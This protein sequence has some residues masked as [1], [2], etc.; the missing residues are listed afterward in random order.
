MADIILASDSFSLKKL[1]SAAEQLEDAQNLMQKVY[2]AVFST[3]FWAEANPFALLDGSKNMNVF[4]GTIDEL[5]TYQQRVHQKEETLRTLAQRIEAAVREL[6]ETDQSFRGKLSGESRKTTWERFKSTVRILVQPVSTTAILLIGAINGLF[7][8]DAAIGGETRISGFAEAQIA[9]A[10][11]QFD[12]TDIEPTDEEINEIAA[13]SKNE[14][15]LLKQFQTLHADKMRME[16]EAIYAEF[17]WRG[18]SVT[19][20]EKT[21]VI[22]KASGKN[23]LRMLF[24]KLYNEKLD[25]MSD[26]EKYRRQVDIINAE[27]IGEVQHYQRYGVTS[28]KYID[29]ESVGQCTW[30]AGTTLI[31]RKRIAEG[32]DSGITCEDLLNHGGGFLQNQPYKYNGDQYSFNSEEGPFTEDRLRQLLDK[33]PEGIEIYWDPQGN[34]YGHAIVLTD[35]EMSDNGIVFYAD[36]GVNNG[37]SRYAHGR[38]VV[39]QT[40]LYW[41]NHGSIDNLRRVYYLT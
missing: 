36:D 6:A 31:R 11:R 34:G 17:D 22:Q 26:Y 23:E 27:Y 10:Y 35:Y 18:I 37:S 29:G 15:D 32:K 40:S 38:V 3:S 8:S 41:N 13:N 1:R 7:S 14:A 5:H 16:S 39:N 9:N 4:D 28:E 24:E 25:A 2:D 30:V 19:E 21:A 20:E 33:H 12:W